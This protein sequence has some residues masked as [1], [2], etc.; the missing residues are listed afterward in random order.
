MRTDGRKSALKLHFHEGEFVLNEF[1]DI[2]NGKN[3][4]LLDHGSVGCILDV[5]ANVGAYSVFA[6]IHYP[7]SRIIACEPSES[8][9]NLLTRN[10]K[11]NPHIESYNVGLYDTDKRTKLYKGKLDTIHASIARNIQC[12]TEYEMVRLVNARQFLKRLRALNIDILKLDTQGCE[13][14][15]LE[16][17]LTRLKF[18]KVIYVEYHSESDRLKINARLSPTHLLCHGQISFPHRGRLAYLHKGLNRSVNRYCINT[19][20]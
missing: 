7:D 15:I 1:R 6:G 5:G 4:P 8:V 19:G 13:V 9:Y 3:Y 11:I 12:T 18:I 20:P 10:A 17:L 2:L 16:A 14:P